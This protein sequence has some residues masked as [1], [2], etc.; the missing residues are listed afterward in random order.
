MGA[1]PYLNTQN[2]C[3]Q[4]FLLTD[5]NK[6]VTSGRGACICNGI[7]LDLT[8]ALLSLS[9]LIA[10]IYRAAAALPWSGVQHCYQW[11]L[12]FMAQFI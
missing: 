5:M 1:L 12:T 4:R 8:L 6:N 11:Q 2:F 10:E 3:W 7:H 9:D